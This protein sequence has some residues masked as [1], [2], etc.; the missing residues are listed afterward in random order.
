MVARVLEPEWLDELS[1]SDPRALRA[2]R[3]LARINAWM[4]QPGIMARA[5]SRHR[6]GR[7][8][9]SLIDLGSG[10]GTF[11]L[12]VAQRLA[13]QWPHLAVTVVDRQN[14]VTAATR[15]ALRALSWTLNVVSADVIDFLAQPSV[16]ADVITTNLFLHHFSDDAL[17]R[18]LA[19]IA[20]R[21]RL[22]VACEPRRSSFALQGSRLVWAIG[23]GD[24]VRHDSVVSV[25]AGFNGAEITAL[26]PQQPGW[27][28]QEY[29]ARLFTHAFVAR[30]DEPVA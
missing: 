7:P 25:R 18:L 20:K 2:R 11:L 29:G 27:Q 15:A 26:W 22:F 3:D 19:A 24:V 17:A 21:T 16:E 5:L 30:R 6:R 8:P 1:A 14:A 23:C 4:F 28:L 13:P 9:R 12:S 10:D